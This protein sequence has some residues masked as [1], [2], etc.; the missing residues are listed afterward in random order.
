MV[1]VWG[2]YLVKR[3]FHPNS[4][5]NVVI[6]LYQQQEVARFVGSGVSYLVE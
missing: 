5:A 4:K 1:R 2:V 3:N 6:E